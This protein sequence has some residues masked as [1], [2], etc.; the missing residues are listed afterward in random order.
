MMFWQDAVIQI[1]MSAIASAGFAVFYRVPPSEYLFC[2][3]GGA[4]CWAV[5][6]YTQAFGVKESFAVFLAAVSVSILSRFLA[7]R[8]KCP[9]TVFLVASIFPLVPGAYIYYTVYYLLNSQSELS[10]LN[11]ERTF[12]TAVAIAFGIMLVTSFPS[13]RKRIGRKKQ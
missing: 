8:R 12:T 5:Y 13:I 1:F 7:E 11:F 3:L 2:G 10:R 6:I 9:V 4:T